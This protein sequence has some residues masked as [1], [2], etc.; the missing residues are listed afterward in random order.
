M[1]LFRGTNCKF[2]FIYTNFIQ[3]SIEQTKVQV[4]IK[5]GAEILFFSLRFV[6]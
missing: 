1:R 5:I 2:K 6:D 3:L 4:A